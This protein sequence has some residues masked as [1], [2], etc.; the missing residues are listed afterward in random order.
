MLALGFGSA[1]NQ[2]MKA[3][4]IT[5]SIIPA[6]SLQTA[7][8]VLTA[9]ASSLLPSSSSTS[10]SSAAAA[11]LA[12][13]R[14]GATAAF[15]LNRTRI[16]LEGLSSYSVISI[17]LMNTA[18]VLFC[19]VP[20]QMLTP[21]SMS[22]KQDSTTAKIENAAT[23]TFNSLSIIC[24][25]SGFTTSI[26]FGL[27]G[28]YSKSALGLGNDEAFITFFRAT[29]GVRRI[30]YASMIASLVCLKGMMTLSTFLYFK[31]R[32]RYLLCGFTAALSVGSCIVWSPIVGAAARIIYS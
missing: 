22:S 13:L 30:G 10:S 7:T 26:I 29:E 15:D 32:L 17:L 12:L 19:A 6:S 4:G 24:I 5:P 14:G 8:N 1:T 25:I 16:R 31:G 9:A 11:S 28:L 18:L 3:G 2:L 21:T 20:K 27:L 23:V